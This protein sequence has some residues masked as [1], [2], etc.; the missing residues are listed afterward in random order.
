MVTDWSLG[1]SDFST[2]TLTLLC[3]SHKCQVNATW[4]VVT[5]LQHLSGNT[6]NLSIGQILPGGRVRWVFPHPLKDSGVSRSLPSPII[7]FT[8]MKT[9]TPNP[10]PCF[11]TMT[12]GTISSVT[13]EHN[14]R[15]AINGKNSLL[16]Q[17][18]TV[19]APRL[20]VHSSPLLN[21]SHQNNNPWLYCCV[22]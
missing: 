5:C 14:S 3:H 13:A 21:T 22:Q 15:E 19:V 16:S 1:L 8:M 11:H 20:P 9:L 6:S 12:L 2:I 4:L 10:N 7:V 18:T 17:A